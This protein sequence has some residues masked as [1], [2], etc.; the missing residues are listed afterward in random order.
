MKKIVALLLLLVCGCFHDKPA[1]AEASIKSVTNYL[2]FEN[3]T[4][5]ELKNGMWVVDEDYLW[6][7]NRTGDIH[8][9]VIKRWEPE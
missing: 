8:R 2:V 6:T 7:N 3:K 5:D 9:Q 4:F 1:P